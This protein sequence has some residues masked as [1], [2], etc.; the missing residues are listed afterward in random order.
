MLTP[1]PTKNFLGDA[2]SRILPHLESVRNYLLATLNSKLIANLA[3]EDLVHETYI[4]ATSA[5]HSAEFSN[6]V[7]LL[8]W[9]KRIATN[10]AISSI[11]KKTPKLFHVNGSSGNS[12]IDQLFDSGGVTPSKAVSQNE[13]RQLLWIAL[14]KLA[15]QHREVIE[16]HYLQHKSFVEIAEMLG[17]TSGAIRG[18][19]RTALDHLRDMLGDMARY[20]STR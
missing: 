10:T 19:H 1:D 17:N 7:Q 14:S 5:Y 20:L 11:R 18:L 2:E 9:L 13:N 3:I 8:A 12:M 6:D 15:P 16:L 4:K